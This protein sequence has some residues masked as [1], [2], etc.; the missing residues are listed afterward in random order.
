MTQNQQRV[1]DR[2]LALLLISVA[3][4]ILAIFVTVG[5]YRHTF[6]G[7]LAVTSI[8]WANF[9]GFIGGIFGPLVSFVTLLAVLKTVYMQRELLDVQKHEFT[10]LLEFQRNESI[11]QDEQLVLA[12]SEAN[13][14]KVQAYQ[15]IILNV[16]ESFSNE[17]RLDS[18]EMFAAA[19]KA[20]L[21]HLSVLQGVN[22][23]AKYRERGDEAR[24][25]VADFKILALELSVAEFSNV[26]EVK[27][28]FA[29]RLL[30]ILNGGTSPE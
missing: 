19:D 2:S 3:V 11:K 29:P 8:E 15:T 17:F 22:A 27:D 9:G 24:K 25:K 1:R 13:R 7:N 12:K 23:S 18:N 6:G 21:D 14:A 30:E 28:K 20:S 5:V 16:V 10:Q 4:V 26:R